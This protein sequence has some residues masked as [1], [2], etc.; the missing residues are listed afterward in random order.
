MKEQYYTL[1]VAGL[2]RKLRLCE[3]NEHLD[4]ASFV[5]LGDV[6]MTVRSAQELLRRSPEFDVVLT[7]EAKSIPLAHEIARQ[8]GKG[9]VLARKSV[10]VYM[11]DPVCVEV[12]SIT[13][14]DIQRLYLGREDLDSLR[15]KRVLIVDDVISTGMS[16]KALE[17]LAE[18]AGCTVVG[19]AAIL[20]EGDAAGRDDIIFLEKLPVFPK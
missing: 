1:Q 14:A 3:A 20:A 6:E 12:K 18:K 11:T 17:A 7:A 13:T 15:G 5:I 4:I 8:S 16:L 19:K 2:T 10:K 9:Y